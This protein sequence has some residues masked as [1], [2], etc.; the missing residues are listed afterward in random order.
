MT[1]PNTIT[2]PT[3][4]APKRPR[5]RV[6]SILNIVSL[7]LATLLLAGSIAVGVWLVTAA[8]VG[9]VAPAARGIATEASR[10]SYGGDAYTGIQ[11]AAADTE[12]SVVAGANSINKYARDMRVAELNTESA[13]W[14]HL[15]IGLAAL[16]IVLASINFIAVLQRCGSAPHAAS[17]TE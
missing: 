10:E 16:L 9:A 11:N 17:R 15:W 6:P 2:D 4:P 13:W 14:G 1:L 3:P 7:A 5:R 12:N 8:P